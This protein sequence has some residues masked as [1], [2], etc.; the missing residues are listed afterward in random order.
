MAHFSSL[1]PSFKSGSYSKWC[2]LQKYK[3]HILFV[4][5]RGEQNSLA[6]ELL[7]EQR[8]GSRESRPVRGL[9]AHF[10]GEESANQCR[11]RIPGSGRYLEYKMATF[12]SIL[13]WKVPR[14]EEPS[15]EQSMGHKGSTEWLSTDTHSAN[16]IALRQRK[17]LLEGCH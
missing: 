16:F 2:P 3:R 4:C 17:F 10:S 15:R 13:A 6:W 12:S 1:L 11:A 7:L 8:A 14:T 9:V 5:L